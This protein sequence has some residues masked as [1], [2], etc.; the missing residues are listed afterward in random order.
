MCTLASA[1]THKYTHIHR[2]RQRNRQAGRQIVRWRK[3]SR[4]IDRPT[5]KFLNHAA[6]F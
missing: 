2:E 4:Q 5:K 6:M 1:N 3:A